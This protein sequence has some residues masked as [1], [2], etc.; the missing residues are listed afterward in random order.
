MELGAKFWDFDC[1]DYI[2][3]PKNCY[4]MMFLS[5]NQKYEVT[6]KTSNQ[7]WADTKSPLYIQFI[8]IQGKTPKKVINKTNI[9]F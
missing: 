2:A 8:G 9:V 6:V 7:L 4:D 3:C 5:G 1:N